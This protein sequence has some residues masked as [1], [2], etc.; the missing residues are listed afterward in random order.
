MG[1]PKNEPGRGFKEDQVEIRITKP[2]RMSR[3]VVTQQQWRQVIGTEPWWYECLGNRWWRGDWASGDDFP[4]VI[5]IWD[6]AM[7]F[8]QT[9]TALERETGRLTATQSYR[10]PT[11]AEWE[12]ACR[13]G[14]T[15]AYS[16]L[17]TML[18]NSVN[19]PGSPTTQVADCRT[20]RR[21]A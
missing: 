6:D 13:A 15:T 19:M 5:V 21:K 14:T 11:D 1:S 16:Y 3:T 18:A 8:C 4:V 9:L 7:F 10:L 20:S 17:E 2:F 12:Y